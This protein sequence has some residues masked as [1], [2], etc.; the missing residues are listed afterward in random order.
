MIYQDA[1]PFF[2]PIITPAPYRICPVG[3][4]ITAGFTDNPNWTVPFEFGYRSG[5]YTRLTNSG[6]A[7]QLVGNS[8]QPWDGA[9]GTVT[10]T[11]MP[12]LRFVNQDHHEGYSGQTTSFVLSNIGNWLGVDQPHI[13]LLLIGINDIGEGSTAEPTAAELNLSN[14]VVTVV[15]KSP[16]THLIVAQ[17]TPYSSYNGRDYQV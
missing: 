1:L 10:N 7:F 11:P 12:D 15:N 8:P 6:M 14:I 13:I 4:S 3:D 16:G 5:L 9:N 17:I 2:D